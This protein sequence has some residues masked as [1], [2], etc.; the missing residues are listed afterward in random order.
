MKKNI[1][2]SIMLLLAYCIGLAQPATNGHHPRY[3]ITVT[4]FDKKEITGL[5]MKLED[6]AVLVFTGSSKEWKSNSIGKTLKIAYSEI[7]QIKLK[8]R[9]RLLKGALIG[10]GIGLAPI[11][12]ASTLIKDGAQGGAFVSIITAPLGLVT[13]SIVGAASKRNFSIYG[14]GAQF[15][16]FKKRIKKL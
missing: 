1:F 16:D 9:N 6:S 13:G 12:V 2:I 11:V 3:Q 5:L 14:K 7:Q 15:D 10:L 8:K 4:S